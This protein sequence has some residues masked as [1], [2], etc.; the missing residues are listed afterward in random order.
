MKRTPYPN[1]AA[2]ITAVWLI[3]YAM[4][5]L[6]PVKFVGYLFVFNVRQI[7]PAE[8]FDFTMPYVRG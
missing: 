1:A 4:A 5:C 6:T 7:R 8:Y 3:A 2:W